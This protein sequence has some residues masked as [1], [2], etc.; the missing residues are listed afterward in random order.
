MWKRKEV[1]LVAEIGQP[2]AYSAYVERRSTIC[3]ERLRRNDQN[4]ARYVRAKLHT[5]VSTPISQFGGN[6]SRSDLIT[7]GKFELFVGF[8][9]ET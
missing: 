1:N 9:V 3:E 2:R 8:D 6:Y 5:S 7:R 4:L